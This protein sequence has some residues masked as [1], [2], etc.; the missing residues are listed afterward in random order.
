MFAQT[1]LAS[2]SV[3]LQR[4]RGPSR[5]VR[6]GFSVH[7]LLLLLSV[8][9]AGGAW[10]SNFLAA[11]GHGLVLSNSSAVVGHGRALSN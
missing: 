2:W 10:G 8:W 7:Q 9:V 3:D 5:R 6:V 11:V 1:S 4:L